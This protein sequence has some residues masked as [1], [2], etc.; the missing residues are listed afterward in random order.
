MIVTSAYKKG[1][2]EGGEGERRGRGRGGGRG[3]GNREGEREDETDTYPV[4]EVSVREEWTNALVSKEIWL[5]SIPVA[6]TR[7]FIFCKETKCHPSMRK[8]L[9]INTVLP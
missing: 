6:S 1:E 8:P 4:K 3:R 9:I 2:G 5:N 7:D